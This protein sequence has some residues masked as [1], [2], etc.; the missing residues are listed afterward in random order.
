MCR[1][2]TS[3]RPQTRS[4]QGRPIQNRAKYVEQ[5]ESEATM[6]DTSELGLF[7]IRSINGR[8]SGEIHITPEVNG[9]PIEMELDTGASVTLISTR[10]WEQSLNK[11]PLETTSMVLKTYTGEL[12][13]IRGQVMVKVTYQGQEVNHLPLLVVEGSG[14]SLFGRNWLHKIQLNWG[15]IKRVSTELDRLME[16][17]PNLFKDG[18]G[19]VKNYQVKL[20][21]DSNAKPKFCKPRSVPFALKEAIEN[22]L[23]RLEQLG[24]VTKVNYSEW[25][26]PIVA[27]PK[28]DGG[29]RICG[30]Y[31]VTIN[32][33]LEMD[34]YPLPTPEDLF[35]TVSGAKYFSKLDLSHAYQQVELEQKSRKLVTVSTHRGLYQY[36]RLPFEVASA[37][38]IFQQLMEQTLQGI[39]GVV[40]YLDDLLITGRSPPRA[41]E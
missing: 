14:P 19:T 27:V 24:V 36:N 32:P 9:V 2:Q 22:D 20:S 39:Q 12:L 15:E 17:F 31:K 40:C 34:R 28:T 41:L 25:A 3:N 7:T 37:P 5:E 11:I 1:Q 16:K 4:T 13:K 6:S 38:A 29:V 21:V 23:G 26:A 35:A 30:D 10:V 33:V 18:L 8:H